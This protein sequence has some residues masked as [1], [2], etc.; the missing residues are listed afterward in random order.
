[1]V[2]VWVWYCYGT[3]LHAYDF[4][5]RKGCYLCWTLY[6]G[7]CVCRY[8]CVCM[9]HTPHLFHPFM[10]GHLSCS[11][12]LAIIN[13]SA[14]NIWSIYLFELMFWISSDK[15]PVE[16]LGHVVV[17]FSMLEG[18]SKLFSVVSA[19]IYN[20]Q[21]CTRVPFSSTSLPTLVCWFI[22]KSHHDQCEV[23]FHCGFDLNFPGD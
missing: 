21:N 9:C 15:Y 1:M 16:L 6:V 19:S 2:C 20:P 4:V 7:L 18:T 13:N 12:I 17:L 14:M 10:A 5:I 8:V 22:D 23:I 3:E 11:H